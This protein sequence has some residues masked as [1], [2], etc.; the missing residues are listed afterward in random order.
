MNDSWHLC[1]L[2]IVSRFTR[3]KVSLNSRFL[4]FAMNALVILLL[5]CYANK[6]ASRSGVFSHW[7]AKAQS[8]VHSTYMDSSTI[9]NNLLTE[10]LRR[11]MTVLH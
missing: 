11:L 4:P 8:L 7:I 10:K 3:F 9:A 5:I 1:L 6:V 2:V